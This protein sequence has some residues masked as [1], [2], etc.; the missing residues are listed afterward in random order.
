MVFKILQDEDIRGIKEMLWNGY[1]QSF[2]ANKYQVSQAHIANISSGRFAH[3]IPW[4]DGTEGGMPQWRKLQIHRRRRKHGSDIVKAGGL[5]SKGEY[6]RLGR[7]VDT[8]LNPT[9]VAG[10]PSEPYVSRDLGDEEPDRSAPRP[11]A[12]G[13]QG[14]KQHPLA[15]QAQAEGDD[16]LLQACKDCLAA[17]S[18]D[19][20]EEDIVYNL[21]QQVAA[22]KRAAQSVV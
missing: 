15:V 5:L 20:W 10:P 13:P 2:T 11:V 18:P 9:P 22:A 1:T 6:E 7:M 14:W 3:R 16:I 21:I 19:I 4:E 17:A 8:H 12:A